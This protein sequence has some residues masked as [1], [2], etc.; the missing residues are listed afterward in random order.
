MGAAVSRPIVRAHAALCLAAL[1]YSGYNVVLADSLKSVSPV[2]F[3]LVRE[4]AALVV[5]Y[6]WAAVAEGPLRLPRNRPD[7]KLFAA[8]GLTLGLFQ[9]CF[10]VGVRLTDASTAAVFQCVEPTTAAVLAAA[11]GAERLTA[12]KVGSAVLAGAGV[13]VLQLRQSPH[14]AGAGAGRVLGAL[15]LFC[16]GVGIATYCLLQKRLVRGEPDDGS[17]DGAADDTH[18]DDASPDGTARAAAE[19][20]LAPRSRIDSRRAHG[21]MATPVSGTAYG[22]ITVTAHA[23]A[24]SLVVMVLAAAVDS[25]FRIED[26]APLSVAALRG[27]GS[28]GK[29]LF[30]VVYAVLL[31]SV[32]GYSLRAWAN[33]TVDASTL[34]LY[35][36]VQPPATALI[37]LLVNPSSQKYGWPEIGSTVL[38]MAAVWTATRGAEKTPK[39]LDS[40]ATCAV[41]PAAASAPRPHASLT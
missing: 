1:I 24:T 28:S 9:L 13:A 7:A 18:P 41:A 35:N 26:P 25:A 38:V 29:A 27:L 22:P 37:E 16:Q 15:L 19:P 30:A 33:K 23:Y 17:S 21:P 32:I 5:L 6:F 14:A 4:A 34:V 10:A 2:L 3:S 11:V 12:A 39:P 20:M 8:L 40:D 31:S 36:A